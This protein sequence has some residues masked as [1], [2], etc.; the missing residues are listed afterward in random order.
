MKIEKN[1]KSLEK[2]FYDILDKL[3]IYESKTAL[4]SLSAQLR[5]T[6]HLFLNE[7]FTEL[8]EAKINYPYKD[9]E[10][11]PDDARGDCA[12]CSKGY[13]SI[14]I[15]ESFSIT[16]Y[17]KVFSFDVIICDRCKN[18]YLENYLSESD[19]ITIQSD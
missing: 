6:A 7:I 12:E 19:S 17:Y 10:N 5:K 15:K 14:D 16:I 3:E 8:P 11:L 13:L 18:L 1:Y 4:T 2:R 9:L